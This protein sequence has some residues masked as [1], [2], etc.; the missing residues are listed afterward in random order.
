MP[1]L[2]TWSPTHLK[3]IVPMFQTGQVFCP[4]YEKPPGI[5]QPIYSYNSKLN[6]YSYSCV[7]INF[8][9]TIKIQLTAVITFKFNYHLCFNFATSFFLLVKANFVKDSCGKI[10]QAE[11]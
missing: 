11:P 3:G 1:D 2:Q 10:I 9:N 7:F 5:L 4:K 8:T 6:S